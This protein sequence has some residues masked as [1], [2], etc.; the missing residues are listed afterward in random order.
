MAL[1]HTARRHRQPQN[2][3][4]PSGSAAKRSGD[5]GSRVLT[6]S[7]PRDAGTVLAADES[8]WP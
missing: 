8:I 2:S 4:D 6:A 7:E 3:I 5:R 1:L